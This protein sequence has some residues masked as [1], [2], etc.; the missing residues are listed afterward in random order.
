MAWHAIHHYARVTPRKARLVADL[1]RG[2]HVNEALDILKFTKKR[3][4]LMVSKVLRSAIANAD[5]QEADVD[6]LFIQEILVNEEPRIKRWR[7]KDRG[8]A[9][10]FVKRTSHIVVTVEQRGK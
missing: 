10:P 2:R 5:E 8:R 1:I 4:S 3:S 6:A 9:H 7:P